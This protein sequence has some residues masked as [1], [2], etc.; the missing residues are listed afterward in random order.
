MVAAEQHGPWQ[1][2]TIIFF[3]SSHS[4]IREFGNSGPARGARTNVKIVYVILLFPRTSEV[5]QGGCES[6][7]PMYSACSPVRVLYSAVRTLSQSVLRCKGGAVKC[8]TL[9]YIAVHC[10]TVPNGQ[11]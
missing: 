4:T 7:M 11:S 1:Q 9:L 2:F 3:V 10:C 8:C 5:L 6:R